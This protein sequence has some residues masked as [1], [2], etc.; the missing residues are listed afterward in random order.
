MSFLE[1]FVVLGFMQGLLIAAFILQNRGLKKK[2]SRYFAY[3]LI[4]LSVVGL[5]SVLS[6]YYEKL[7]PFWFIFF[8][9]IGDDIPWVM[10]L[11]IPLFL[12][13]VR[14]A[15]VEVSIPI[16]VL[17]T[18]FFLFV[19]INLLIDLDLDFSLI[20]VATLTDNRFIFY[21]LEDYIA[22]AMAIALHITLYFRIIRLARNRWLTKLWRLSALLIFFWLLLPVDVL[23]F[24][25]KG[26]DAL[27]KLIWI[28][29][30][31]YIH[32]AMYTGLLQLNLLKSQKNNQSTV[33]SR[34]QTGVSPGK[35]Q[36]RS[37]DIVRRF[38]Q[39]MQ[40]EKI[41]KEA[42]IGREEIAK[43]LNVSSGY[44][45]T[46]LS[47]YF[48]ETLTKILSNY[49]V[50]E[51]V[52]LLQDTSF[53]HYDTTSIGLEAGFQSKSAFYAAF[54]EKMGRTPASFRKMKS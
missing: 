40:E 47:D 37:S 50:E 13:F 15:G 11:Y 28:S 10:L 22:I 2:E 17:T 19:I 14:T 54:R 25:Q 49:R 20:K 8:D 53:A 43:K 52:R 23:L 41:Y 42:L 24:K 36:A 33:L 21:Q 12:F 51:A 44:L 32:W 4:L 26:I 3:F 16:W 18:P 34:T 1:T 29:V 39:L 48:Q 6:Q 38:E 46:I 30:A 9:I 45:S 7:D 27:V 5:D 31:I 35:K